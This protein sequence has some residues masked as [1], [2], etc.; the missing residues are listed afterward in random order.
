MIE[1]A[2][3]FDDGTLLDC[4]VAIVGAGAA[5]ITLALGLMEKAPKLDVLLVEAGGR[6]FDFNAQTAYFAHERLEPDAHPPLELYRRRM[7]GGTTSVWGGRC[8][9][10]SP[11]DFL[12]RPEIGRN[13]WP[14]GYGDVAAHYPKALEI[15]EGGKAEFTAGETFADAS[16][17]LSREATGE[18]IADE[19]ERFSPPT[20]LGKRYGE[21]LASA[22]RVRVLLDAPCVSL[23]TDESGL[24]STGCLLRCGDNSL[25]VAARATVIAAGGLETPRLL[26]SSKDAK[27]N[28]LGN[29]H[30]QVGR[31]YMTHLFATLGLA[32]FDKSVGR[33]D[34]DY[35]KSHDG[36]WCRRMFRL[37]ESARRR[38]HLPN[39]VLRPTIPAV[40]DPA[41]GNAILSA[42]FFAKR[43]LVPEYARRLSAMPA[44]NSAGRQSG[45]HRLAAHAGNLVRGAP[46][47][48]RFTAFW[49]K[50][51]W[52]AQ[53]QIPSL[54]LESAE[55]AYPLE[56]NLEQL[57]DPQSRVSLGNGLDPLGMQR[58][59]VNWKPGGDFAAHIGAIYDA[60]GEAFRRA[61]L[62]TI[63]LPEE[64]REKIAGACEAQGGHHIGT[65]RMSAE[66]RG[67]VVDGNCEV[68]GTKGLFVAG[69]AV[70]PTSGFA[71][72]T[73]T[74]SALALR[75]ADHLAATV[76]ASANR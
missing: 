28:G 61:G 6:R 35:A 12:P 73:L 9:P 31:T 64:Q 4:D 69:S 30:D 47:L 68:W 55:A 71:N 75:L 18:L 19:I 27:P 50:N 37:S 16:A 72:P 5:G 1:S 33:R 17:G 20:D 54:F 7:L 23:T 56:I 63:V 59:V 52:L 40:A 41:H 66:A 25:R 57:P 39:F 8:I 70:F 29:D 2:R 60:F 42:V 38:H 11:D 46:S 26:L 10:L 15:L 3:S 74:I 32:K 34:L 58:L 44:D 53:R 76:P 22:A 45:A 62:G 49:A 51:R 24:R 13:G 43:F 65:A 48:L 14:I 21:R 67:G 36:V